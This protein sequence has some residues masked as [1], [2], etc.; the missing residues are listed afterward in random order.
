MSKLKKI[1]HV[2]ASKKFSGAENV[3]CT[4]IDNFK[5]EYDMAYCSPIGS[6][7]EILKNRKINYYGIEKLSIK[8]LKKVIETYNPD[9][10]HAHDYTA[11]L[12]AS[13]SGF[14]GKII[15]H[16]HINA[17]FAKNWNIKSILYALSMN[18]YQKVIGVSDAVIN[19]AIFKKKIKDKYITLY[20]YVNKEWVIEKSN[21]YKYNNQFDLFFIGRLNELKNPIEFIEIVY[22]LKEKYENIKAVIIGDGE[23]KS[24]CE[25]KINEYNLEKNIKMLGF[26]ENPFPIIKNCKIGIMPSLVEG[27]GLTA[28]ESMI[29]DKPVL[30]SGVGGLSEIFKDNREL[31]CSDINDYCKKIFDLNGKNKN[32]NYSKQTEKFCNKKDWKNKLN[33]IYLN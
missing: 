20:N 13:L 2:L 9:I 1:L 10:I 25:N 31:I 28:L 21:A 17:K 23:L 32:N 5:D 19:E 15:S 11:S 14:K 18:K 16:L 3:V 6:I 8:N 30:N 33:Q 4:I 22:K 24:E 26:I 7:S 29:L 12:I 27:F